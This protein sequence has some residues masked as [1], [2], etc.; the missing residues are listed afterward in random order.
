MTYSRHEL[1]VVGDHTGR[2]KNSSSRPVDEAAV[3]PTPGCRTIKKAHGDFV[4]SS[5]CIASRIPQYIQ[6]TY[7]ALQNDR[8]LFK[9]RVGFFFYVWRVNRFTPLINRDRVSSR[10]LPN[11]SGIR[12][13][14]IFHGTLYPCECHCGHGEVFVYPVAIGAHKLASL[15]SQYT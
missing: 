4:G 11:T 7:G 14:D 2:K 8:P 13:E 15:M 9:N 12:V 10:A 1:G 6:P 3:A 5:L